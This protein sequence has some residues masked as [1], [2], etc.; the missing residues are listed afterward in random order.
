MPSSELLARVALLAAVSVVVGISTLGTLTKPPPADTRLIT[1]A[2]RPPEPPAPLPPPPSVAAVPAGVQPQPADSAAVGTPVNA[3]SA[4]SPTAKTAAAPTG[5]PFVP[6]PANMAPGNPAPAAVESVKLTIPADSS[7]AGSAAAASAADTSATATPATAT[8][9][10]A[11]AAAP[12]NG[13]FPEIQPLDEP[14]I[15]AVPAEPA[16]PAAKHKKRVARPRAV[17][18]RPKPYEIREFIA[19]R[20]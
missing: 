1:M 16:K 2:P 14:G 12:A 10:T 6:V 7:T 11:V 17:A 15:V 8:P 19:G 3:P 4:A 13:S 18:A 9:A 20:W 5:G